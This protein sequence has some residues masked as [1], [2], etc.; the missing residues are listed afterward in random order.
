MKILTNK[1]FLYYITTKDEITPPLVPIIFVFNSIIESQYNNTKF[2]SLLLDLGVSTKSIGGLNRLKALQKIDNIIKIDNYTAGLANFTFNI[3]SMASLGHINLEI[4]IRP[5]IFYIMSVNTL[6]FLCLA[7]IDKLNVF[8]NN[9]INELVY[10]K[11][12]HS[13]VYRYSYAF[14][15]W[16]AARYLLVAK[17]FDINSY[18]LTKVELCCLHCHFGY[19]LVCYLKAVFHYAGHEVDIQILRHLTKYF[20][21]CQWHSYALGHFNFTIKNN[22]NFNFNI[23]VNIFYIIDKLVLHIVNKTTCFQVGQWLKNISAK[24]VWEQL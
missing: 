18:Y 16:H 8:F 1:V 5:I 6:F 11:F 19:P 12:L 13:V 2:Q 17:S 24:H 9:V 23:I 10:D 4:P 14:K 20:N 7:N 15:M 21:T 3:S 22:V